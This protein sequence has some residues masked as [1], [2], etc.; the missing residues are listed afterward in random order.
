MGQKYIYKKIMIPEKRFY[1]KRK[2]KN[3][4]YKKIIVDFSCCFSFCYSKKSIVFL[5]K[6]NVNE[7]GN[8]NESENENSDFVKPIVA[9]NENVR[10]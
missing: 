10:F 3:N 4:S 9:E 7:T 5:V 6:L 2:N 1:H 8:E